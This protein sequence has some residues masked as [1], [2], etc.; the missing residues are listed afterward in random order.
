MQHGRRTA[1]CL[2]RDDAA[3]GADIMRHALCGAKPPRSGAAY[4]ERRDSEK[5]CKYLFLIEIIV[6]P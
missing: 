5:R 6:H 2:T 3:R 1:T 4:L